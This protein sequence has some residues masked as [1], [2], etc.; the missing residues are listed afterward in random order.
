MAEKRDDED[1]EPN[2]EM[3][4][5]VCVPRGVAEWLC[6]LSVTARV[7]L[8]VHLLNSAEAALRRDGGLALLEGRAEAESW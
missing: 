3:S 5:R 2:F 1:R 7:A 8:A 6:R 4:M